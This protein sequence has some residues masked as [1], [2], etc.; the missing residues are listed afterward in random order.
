MRTAESRA[1]L[2][3]YARVRCSGCGATRELHERAINPVAIRLRNDG[4][5]VGMQAF[6]PACQQPKRK[7]KR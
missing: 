6:C 4:W 7:R 5:R 2:V 1:W 3:R